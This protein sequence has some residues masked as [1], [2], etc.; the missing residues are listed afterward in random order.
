[1]EDLDQRLETAVKRRN[2]LESAVE[3]LRGK[4]ESARAN[5]EAVEAE[6]RAKKVEPDQID[7]TITRLRSRYQELVEQLEQEVSDAT[8]AL[9]PFLK[10]KR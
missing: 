8:K 3:R 5:L 9:E 7:D 6:C 2:T 1:M 10:E 4:L